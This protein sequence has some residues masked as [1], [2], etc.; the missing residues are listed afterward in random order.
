[1]SLPVPRMTAEIVQGVTTNRVEIKRQKR[2]PEPVQP[3]P[4]RVAKPQKSY[5]PTK[6][7]YR[8]DK[9]LTGQG[10]TT[11][12]ITAPPMEWTE[13]DQVAQ[14]LMMSRSEFLRR[15]ARVLI[16]QVCS[17]DGNGAT[18]VDCTSRSAVSMSVLEQSGE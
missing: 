11:K 18:G 1:M 5:T 8:T 17:S 7:R 12:C 9:S 13:I 16:T 6:G 10:T 3:K 15:G 2:Q 4:V 14:S